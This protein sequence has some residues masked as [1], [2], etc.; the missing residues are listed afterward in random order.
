[1]SNKESNDA[2]QPPLSLREQAEELVRTRCNDISKMKAED[3]RDLVH[4]LEVHQV[5]LELQNEELRQSQVELAHSRD[6]Y[7]ELYEFAPTGYVILDRHGK[8]HSA[9]LTAANLLGVDRQTLLHANLSNFVV[10]GSQDDFYLHRQSVFGGETKQIIELP[11]KKSDGGVL[12]VRLESVSFGVG[13]DRRCHTSLIN[14][15][16]Q[17][18]AENALQQLNMELKQ[19]VAEQTTEI[20]LLAEAVAH[21]GEGVLITS[22]G[23][24]WPGPQIVF[25]NEAM[26][27]ITGYTA[28]ELIGQSPRIF[29]GDNTDR[30]TLVRIKAELSAGRSVVAELVN[31]RKDGTPHHVEM[32][33]MPLFNFENRRTHFVSI[34]R[35]ITERKQAQEALRRE[36]EL[37]EG[38]INSA[39]HVI[40]VLGAKGQIRRFNPHLEKLTGWQL[41]DVKGRD[42]FDTFLP[43][44]DRER[45]RTLFTRA[46]QGEPT[47][48]YVN[49]I[50]TKDG[51]EREIE[52]YDAPLT[53]AEGELIG[54]LCTGQDVTDRKRAEKEIRER[55]ERLLAVLNT[56]SDA[57][58]TIDTRGK[59]TDIN[60][61]TEK[62]FGYT[63]SELIGQ[64]VKILMPQPYFNEHDQYI[65]R[66]MQTGVPHIIGTGRE[67]TAKRKDGSI[68]P[69][70]LAVS[71]VEHLGL[72]T[73][74]IRDISE[75]K[76]LQRD[77]LA[78]VEDEKRRIGQELHDGCQQE[79]AGLGMVSQTLLDNIYN[80][81]DGHPGVYREKCCE[82]TNKIVKGIDRALLDVQA[83]A[84]GL[85]PFSLG[86]QGLV[87]ALRM[88]AKKTDE[89]GHVIC[90]FK[91]EQPV[92]ISCADTQLHLYRI[93]QEAVA[94]ALKHSH[95]EHIL[96]ALSCENSHPVLQ[97]ADDGIGFDPTKQQEGLGMKTMTYRAS[98]IG[99]Q[100]TVAPIETGGTIVT[101]TILGDRSYA[102]S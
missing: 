28:D 82:L 57:I 80:G 13:N 42:W 97:I 45:I 55:E 84:K 30:D 50:V 41:A 4:E 83:T 59:I 69:V 1:M 86:K 63:R 99:G 96:I 92:N 6:Q 46:L 12:F 17:K 21:L 27:L 78:A 34:Q 23:L 72:F 65:A 76:K 56:A 90:A 60:P 71:K 2:L 95:A 33:I 40:L 38:I 93:A 102:D 20:R 58:I 88:L 9:N 7:S 24:D 16:Q 85:V 43:Q 8:I 49:P 52:W 10:R 37:S 29:H 79:L 61:A 26:C 94:N 36:Y 31:Y 53:N 48:G 98:L 81:S 67:A 18:I 35:D 77:I 22:N 5:E 73:G 64:N 47:R 66:Y 100:L 51:R 3:V 19:R 25:V 62:M 54:M 91:N 39:H 68:F 14:I 87:S 44:R 70:D 74:V 32:D 11:M 15:S 89:L 75:R 101:C